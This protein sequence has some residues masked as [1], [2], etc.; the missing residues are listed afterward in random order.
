MD[1][2]LVAHNNNKQYLLSILYGVADEAGSKHILHGWSEL[3]LIT[4]Q[5]QSCLGPGLTHLT[6]DRAQHQA[7]THACSYTCMQVN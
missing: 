2:I 1:I 6:Q 5:R 7:G 4:H 3:L